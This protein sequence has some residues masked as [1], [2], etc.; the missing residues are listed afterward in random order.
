[1][2]ATD[3]IFELFKKRPLVGL[4]EMHGLAQE[5][6]VYFALV[7]DPRFATEVGNI[8]LETGSA[9]NQG[10]VDR[11]VNGEHVP[12]PEL[13][14][15]W[16]DTVGWFPAVTG[17]GAIRLYAAIRLANATLPPDKRIKVW[18][19][20]P[21]IDWLTV[22][23]KADWEPLSKQRD[24]HPAEL[25]RREILTKGKKALL[26]YGVGHFGIYPIPTLRMI[27][28]KT[29]PGSLFVVAPYVGYAQKDCAVRFERHITGWKVPSLAWPIQGSTLEV[30]IWR[31]ECDAFAK[32]PN[33]AQENASRNNVGLTAD[34]LLYMGPRDSLLQDGTDPD[35]LMD[36][37]YRAELA[38]R[39][40]LR[41]GEPLPPPNV[42]RQVSRPF[43][44]D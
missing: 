3:G 24:S 35:I 29:N 17:I 34:A 31:R 5:F 25:A 39:Y 13:R 20:E 18:L 9:S 2:P 12:Y 14:K 10:I 23:T 27:L 40:E 22:K 36:L 6:E 16:A 8:L 33:A 1:M 42:S 28:D 41:T 15:V 21:P 19:G 7:R 26:I 11:Y 38:R 44:E 43:L 4:G 37:D 30:D 32:V